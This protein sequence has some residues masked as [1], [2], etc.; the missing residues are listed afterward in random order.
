MKTLP[1]WTIATAAAL[2]I[3]L[4]A[5]PE[6]TNAQKLP[7]GLSAFPSGPFTLY[8]TE[9]AQWVAVNQPP[10]TPPLNYSEQ[11]S[12]QAEMP[13]L[14]LANNGFYVSYNAVATEFGHFRTAT[15]SFVYNFYGELSGGN[16][17][18][19]ASGSGPL[20]FN[21]VAFSINPSNCTMVF[22]RQGTSTA[23]E[24]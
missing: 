21:A 14:V 19:V 1:T 23:T 9:S 16:V 11:V 6:Q 22:H 8:V 12:G 18:L 7:C 5:I 13:A 15:D 20:D 24:S 10:G 17:P 3:G 2:L 4:F